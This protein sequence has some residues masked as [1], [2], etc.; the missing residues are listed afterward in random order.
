[1]RNPELYALLLGLAVGVAV[2]EGL[3]ILHIG[4]NQPTDVQLNWMMV[5]TFTGIAALAGVLWASGEDH[6]P[7]T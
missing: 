1:M 2:V 3:L 4:T 5:L 6:T 7:L